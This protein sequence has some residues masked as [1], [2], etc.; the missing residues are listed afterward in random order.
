MV[1]FDMAMLFLVTYALSRQG[2]FCA[3][4]CTGFYN[5]PAGSESVH[6]NLLAQLTGGFH[7]IS[8]HAETDKERDVKD[9]I[10]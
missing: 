7:Y 4:N 10:F 3:K 6:A 2:H 9:Y 5:S 8:N 1:D